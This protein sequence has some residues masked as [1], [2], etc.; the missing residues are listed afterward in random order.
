MD[1]LIKKIYKKAQEFGII[2]FIINQ[3][4][5]YGYTP[6]YL[7]CLNEFQK[8][9]KEKDKTTDSRMQILKFMIQGDDSDKKK[10]TSK[11]D[12]KGNITY[13]TSNWRVVC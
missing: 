13:Y 4:D 3:E 12:E 5:H 8:F 9:H 2:H 10:A 11:K 6:L 1:K 7:L